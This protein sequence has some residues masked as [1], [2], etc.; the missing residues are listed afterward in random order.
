M[1]LWA[2][3]AALDDVVGTD[4]QIALL[5]EVRRLAERATRWLLRNRA[6]PLDIAAT[7]EFFRPGVRELARPDPRRW[8]P[9]TG[10]GVFERTVDGH[11]GDG[12]PKDLAWSVGTLPDLISALD[13]TTV[14]RSTRRPV[15]EVAE[16]YFALD[17]YLKLDWLRGRILDLP[18]DDRWQSLARAALR[19][20]LH[21]VHSAI[22]AEVLRTSPPG[23]RGPRAGTPLGRD[24]RSGRRTAACACSATSSTAAGST[25]P[26]SRSRSARSGPWCRPAPRRRVAMVE[27][28]ES[29]RRQSGEFRREYTS[30]G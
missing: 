10:G 5:L 11:V 28:G 2:Q 9:R 12:V 4:T 3:I 1:T 30:A 19:E 17:E 26:R 25:S 13:I 7:T 29:G 22:T 15:G 14:A 18:R 16:V 24:D 6:Q 27:G 23:A 20:D 8:S 21:V